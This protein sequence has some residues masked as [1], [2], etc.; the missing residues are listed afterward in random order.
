M[1]KATMTFDARGLGC[2]TVMIELNK[3]INSLSI[4]DILEFISS[5]TYVQQ[6][7]L[8]WSKRTGHKILK[9]IENEGVFRFFVQKG[10]RIRRLQGLGRKSPAQQ[11]Y[12]RNKAKSD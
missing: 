11:Y 1:M 8:S 6:D 4:G 9:T 7:I 3:N 12:R 10:E 5:E 2:P